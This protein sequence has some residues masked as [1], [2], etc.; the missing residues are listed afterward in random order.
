[1]PLRNDL[2]T[3]SK[4]EQ[5]VHMYTPDQL[6]DCLKIV[7]RIARDAINE[8][9]MGGQR[10]TSPSRVIQRS[11]LRHYNDT[12]EKYIMWSELN[13]AWLPQELKAVKEGWESGLPT[14]DIADKIHR[15][16]REVV[17]LIWELLD[18][19]KLGARKGGLSGCEAG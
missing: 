15:D 8:R 7:I 11:E 6:R 2:K 17:M 12:A 4:I 16:H 1:M 14:W 10:M 3:L 13:Y 9:L 5:Q 19:S 18:R